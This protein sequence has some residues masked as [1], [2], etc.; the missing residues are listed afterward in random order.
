M[1]SDIPAQIAQ[2]RSFSRR[3]L[4][5][6]WE[7]LHQRAAPQG[8]RRELLIPFLAYRIQEKAYGGLKPSTRSEL[9]RIARELEKSKDSPKLKVRLKAKTGTRI[10]R[11]WRGETHEVI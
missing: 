3:Q 2:L 7:K 11:E 5:D 1:D 9:R 10:Y 8:I 4:L 6:L